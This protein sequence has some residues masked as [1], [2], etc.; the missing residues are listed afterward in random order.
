VVVPNPLY[1]N[2]EFVASVYMTNSS[3]ATTLDL[4]RG[5]TGGGHW[6]GYHRAAVGLLRSLRR[7]R[8]SVSRSLQS[9]RWSLNGSR[10]AALPSAD[11]GRNRFCEDLDVNTKKY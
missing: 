6:G 2:A 8:A 3:A 7:S 10:A 9:L 5:S 4:D 11:T 1:D